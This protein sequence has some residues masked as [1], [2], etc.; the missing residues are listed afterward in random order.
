MDLQ[1]SSWLGSAV[2][3]VSQCLT[4][5]YMMRI[6]LEVGR[7]RGGLTEGR[8]EFGDPDRHTVEPARNPGIRAGA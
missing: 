4:G 8:D 7:G 5:V 3:L 1:A 2:L 6:G